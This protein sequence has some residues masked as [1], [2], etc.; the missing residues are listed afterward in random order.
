[1]ESPNHNFDCCKNWRKSIIPTTFWQCWERFTDG[2]CVLHASKQNPFVTIWF[3]V[4]NSKWVKK[5]ASIRSNESYQCHLLSIFKICI[6]IRE[7]KPS[8][9]MAIGKITKLISNEQKRC[10]WPLHR[11]TFESISV[12]PFNLVPCLNHFHSLETHVGVLL[13]STSRHP[14]NT[15]LLDTR[16]ANISVTT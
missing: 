12:Y 13:I 6:S 10:L 16:I 9:P 14:F 1:M 11:H 4:L 15:T 7:L 2:F 8:T 3:T 5:T